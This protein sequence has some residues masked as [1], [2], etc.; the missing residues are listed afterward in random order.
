MLDFLQIHTNAADTEG[1]YASVD[2]AWWTA[3][4]SG[5]LG[6]FIGGVLTSI[7]AWLIFRYSE[8]ASD[9]RQRLDRLRDAAVRFA[10]FVS[11]DF[12][13]SLDMK[14]RAEEVKQDFEAFAG[15]AMQVSDPLL[16]LGDY[17]A[18]SSGGDSASS[19]PELPVSLRERHR[20][21]VADLDALAANMVSTRAWVAIRSELRLV[22]PQKIL[23]EADKVYAISSWRQLDADSDERRKVAAEL[24]GEAVTVFVN[25]VRRE[26]RLDTF[27]AEASPLAIIY[28]K[29]QKLYSTQDDVEVG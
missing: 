1:I 22:A 15:K 12:I 6:A 28:D 18:G 14:R 29:V 11:A 19:P 10:Q 16:A 13:S 2:A 8:K 25:S 4:F 9:E 5:L 21:F 7:T 27:E 20:A 24:F 23:E 3:A 26:M 17:P